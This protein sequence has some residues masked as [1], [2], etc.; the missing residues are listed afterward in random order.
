M[1]EPDSL[2]PCPHAR[3]LS[4]LRSLS[5]RVA[6]VLARVVVSEFLRYKKPNAILSFSARSF[7]TLTFLYP[8]LFIISL[9]SSP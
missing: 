7:S 8:R 5:A 6:D 2:S 9:T 4:S 1:L 3:V